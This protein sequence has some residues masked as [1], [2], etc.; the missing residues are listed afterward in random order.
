MLS[1]ANNF[2]VKIR[3]K[4]TMN[5]SPTKTFYLSEDPYYSNNQQIFV[6]SE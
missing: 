1:K 4:E 5:L 3:L 2:F 6:M